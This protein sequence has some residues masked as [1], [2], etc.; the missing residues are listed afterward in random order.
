MEKSGTPNKQV[1]R[2]LRTLRPIFWWLILV[3]VLYGIRTHQRLMEETR[4]VFTVSIQGQPHYD[5][6]TSFDGK[7]IK[8]GQNISLGNHTFV[9]TLPKGEPFSTN[10]FVWYGEH[11]L[12]TLDLKR[13]MGALAVTANP[14]AP[15]LFIRGPE[16][17]VTLTNSSG[18]TASVPTDQYTVESR[19]AHWGHADDVTVLAGPTTE[20]WQIAP[21]L[22]AIQLSCNQSDATFQLLTLDDRQEEAGGF[23]DLI[24]EVPEGN[25][26][27][28]SRHHGHQHEQTVSV[29]AGMTNDNPIEFLY[30]AAFLET[31]PADATVQDTDGH[32]WGVTPLRLSEI[33]PG[34]LQ[35][36]LHRAGYEPV[37]V[38]LQIT[39]NDTS[40]F[41]TN[42][43]SMGYTGA[44]KS[45]RQFLAA[46]KYAQ[47]LQAIGDALVAKPDD[48]DAILLRREAT[49]L[50]K[51]QHAKQLG[52]E[53][54]FIEGG[55]E[56]ALAL[57]SLPDNG[58]IK[59]L[60]AEFKGRE[61]EQIE[62]ERLERLNRP[63]LVYDDILERFQDANLFDDHSLKT[64]KPAKDA[65]EAIASAL[66]YTQPAYK[67]TVNT[68]PRSETYEIVGLQEVSGNLFNAGGLRRFI[69]VCGQTRDDETQILFKVMEFK[70]K[71]SVSMPALLEF[72]DEQEYVPIH[73][74][75][76]PDMNDK[77]KAQLQAG[78][79]NLT[80]R[81]Q[82]A[83][84]QTP[85]P[86]IQ[87]AA[88][89]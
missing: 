17:S 7:P 64:S 82:G 31:V 39:A 57:Q 49:G 9:I 43:V 60:I 70:K 44:M 26:K 25:Y 71:H 2:P 68:S 27:L 8:S 38:S 46:M 1:R 72:K 52:K 3:L 50:G 30:G 80:V 73:P 5:A 23:P 42:L 21:R 58:E 33:S 22:G 40:T 74:S 55:K 47:A 13:T 53:G 51:L 75:R 65:A 45:A 34:T 76:I 86:A 69:I 37:S 35:F 59:Q 10:M 15:L 84:G 36:T 77:L 28:I 4:L 19:Y 66:L 11:N 61:P 41:R 32:Q 62:R 83:I 63:K 85:A 48:A 67:I 6:S 56:L 88:P 81:I 24:T 20:T 16:W 29:K 87:P 79:S 14:P 89:Q 12:G 54:D 78:V 18:L